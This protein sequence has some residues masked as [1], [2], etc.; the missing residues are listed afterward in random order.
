M[1]EN[2][3][4][5]TN[6]TAKAKQSSGTLYLPYLIVKD[7]K[8]GCSWQ[9]EQ[10]AQSPEQTHGMPQWQRAPGACFSDPQVCRPRPPCEPAWG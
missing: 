9:R 3:R 6:I 10:Q 5:H 8:A 7:R 4:R 1:E 2:S